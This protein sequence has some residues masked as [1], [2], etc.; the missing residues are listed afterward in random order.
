[1]GYS[2]P[3]SSIQ[4]CLGFSRQEYWSGELLA[5][6]ASHSLPGGPQA[7]VKLHF[8]R[9]CY[10][11]T[12]KVKMVTYNRGPVFMKRKGMISTP[13]LSLILAEVLLVSLHFK[14]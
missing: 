10:P 14:K 13:P 3:G 6:N 2:L 8:V 9:F 1:M 4:S 7:S 11:Q 12:Q 5:D